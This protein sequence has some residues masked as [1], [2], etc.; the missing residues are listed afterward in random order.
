MN[1][2]ELRRISQINYFGIFR[3]HLDHL[4]KMYQEVVPAFSEILGAGRPYIGRLGSVSGKSEASQE[5]RVFQCPETEGLSSGPHQRMQDN[6]WI[7]QAATCWLH[8]ASCSCQLSLRWG[9]SIA[10]TA[11]Y[12]ASTHKP[13]SQKSLRACGSSWVWRNL[14]EH[15]I[16]WLAETLSSPW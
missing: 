11:S 3:L 2:N 4:C 8:V 15:V 7:M 5:L 16:S 1:R 13:H 9:W 14:A 12:S 10:G 6:E